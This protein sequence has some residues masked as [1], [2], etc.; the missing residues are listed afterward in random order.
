V[1]SLLFIIEFFGRYRVIGAHIGVRS[2]KTS[3]AKANIFQPR[4]SA[5]E[6]YHNDLK[7]C[8]YKRI[9]ME[10]SII[11]HFSMSVKNCCRDV[12][13]RRWLATHV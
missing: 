1:S 7:T 10:L 6:V 12:N 13:D 5:N 8:V 2:F 4:N 11:T 9:P 3:S